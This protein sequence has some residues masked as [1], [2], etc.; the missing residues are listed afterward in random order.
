MEWPDSKEFSETSNHTNKMTSRGYSPGYVKD[1]EVQSNM[2]HF[3]PYYITVIDESQLVYEE[4]ELTWSEKKL[5]NDYKKR[6][7]LKDIEEM[8][9]VSAAVTDWS[10]EKYETSQAKHGDKIFQKFKKQL[11]LCPNQCLR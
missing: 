8:M 1:T 11:R 5:L 4:S 3:V 10:G 6:E 9:D 7:G 2:I